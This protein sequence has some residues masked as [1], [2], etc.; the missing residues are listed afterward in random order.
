MVTN[1]LVIFAPRR[2]VRQH[3]PGRPGRQDRQAG[4]DRT[5]EGT[6]TSG[7]E[8]GRGDGGQLA[9][10][11]FDAVSP[12]REIK[13]HTSCASFSAAKSPAASAFSSSLLYATLSGWYLSE[14]RR[15]A[16][17][18]SAADASLSMPRSP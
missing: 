6:S 16:R 14:S 2:L 8:S 3:L 11:E 17:R 4:I 13:S 10:W 12:P 18:T 1:H 9:R 5:M 7:M 15:N